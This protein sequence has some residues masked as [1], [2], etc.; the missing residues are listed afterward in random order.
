MSQRTQVT[1]HSEQR[2][3]DENELINVPVRVFLRLWS[4]VESSQMQMV[5][6]WRSY[7][8][9]KTGFVFWQADKSVTAVHIGGPNKT[10]Q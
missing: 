1:A 6:Q 8:K 2:L 5:V 4:G 7:D 10:S 3:L 9:F